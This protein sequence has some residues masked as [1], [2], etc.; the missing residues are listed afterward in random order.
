M[1]AKLCR[2][3]VVGV[4][5]T[6]MTGCK[7]DGWSWPFA[8]KSATPPPYA[9]NTTSPSYPSLPSTGAT[10][11]MVGSSRGDRSWRQRHAGR[12]DACVRSHHAPYPQLSWFHCDGCFR[13][14][15]YGPLPAAQPL[16]AA[17]STALQSG[18]YPTTYPGSAPAA[19]GTAGS[20]PPTAGYG[21]AAGSYP[22]NSTTTTAPYTADNST[23]QGAA[24]PYATTSQPTRYVDTAGRRATRATATGTSGRC[25]GIH[26]SG[27]AL[28]HRIRI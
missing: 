10:P 9:S 27:S 14:R 6:G 4:L 1:R 16:P 7:S 5:V 12:I 25:C 20:M 22:P 2:L 26:G 28:W 21:Q 17:G 13:H 3:A 8:K 23:P 11:S 24:A 19:T 18:Y 15:R